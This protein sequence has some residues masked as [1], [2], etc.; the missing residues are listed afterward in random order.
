MY[1]LISIHVYNM[2]RENVNESCNFNAFY[3]ITGKSFFVNITAFLI[4]YK[5][6]D[7][8]IHTKKS[9]HRIRK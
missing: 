3:L 4:Q 8:G 9:N 7:H 2:Y 1:L 5:K 6:W